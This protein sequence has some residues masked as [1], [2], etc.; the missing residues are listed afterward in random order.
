MILIII[1]SVLPILEEDEEHL[2]VGTGGLRPQG[3]LGGN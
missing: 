2:D 1:F 3:N